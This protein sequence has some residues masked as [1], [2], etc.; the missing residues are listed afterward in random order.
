MDDLLTIIGSDA[1][2][3]PNYCG[4]CYW[5]WED[6]TATIRLERLGYDVRCW[7]D[8]ERDSFGPLS[9]GCVAKKDGEVFRFW[10]G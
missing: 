7:V 10:Y 6:H 5:L 2:E 8:G 9:R 1:A 3:E 4:Q